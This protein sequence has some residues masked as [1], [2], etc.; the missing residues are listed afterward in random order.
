MTH[1]APTLEERRLWRDLAEAAAVVAG[2]APSTPSPALKRLAREARRTPVVGALTCHNPC[3]RLVRLARQYLDQ[4]TA[5][6]RDLQAEL[7][8]RATAVRVLLGDDEDQPA[9][10]WRERKD[11]DG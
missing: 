9:P 7:A 8:A 4:A 3:V 5:G 6:R 11:I 1:P 10:A 2:G